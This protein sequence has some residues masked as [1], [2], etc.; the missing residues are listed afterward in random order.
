V[1]PCNALG[2]R[3]EP[4]VDRWEVISYLILAEDLVKFLAAPGIDPFGRFELGF[5]GL[6][7]QVLM[8][9]LEYLAHVVDWRD[10][11]YA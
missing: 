11:Q 6:K 1:V 8:R 2:A 3:Y 7:P 5:D 9:V 10:A 4:A